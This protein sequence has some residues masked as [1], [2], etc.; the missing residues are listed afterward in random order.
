MSK[1]I[2]TYLLCISLLAA[3]SSK[4]MKDNQYTILT[5]ENPISLIIYYHCNSIL[6]HTNQKNPKYPFNWQESIAKMILDNNQDAIVVVT[7][8]YS[9][10]LVKKVNKLIDKYNIKDIIISGWSAGGN[11]AIRAAA[12]L[13]NQDRQI[14]LLLVDCNHTNQVDIKYI[15]ALKKNNIEINYA[16]NIISWNK[17][18]VLKNIMSQKIPIHYYKLKIPKNFSGSHHIY[19]RNCSI[20]YNLYGYLL[21]AIELNKHYKYGY[22]DYLKKSIVFP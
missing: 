6:P 18:K 20:K 17:N 22:Y 4:Q 2:I 15:K 5:P 11:N 8:E 10:K 12:T 7:Y 14:Q 3:P 21:G 19:N 1:S 16:S 13:A 9:S